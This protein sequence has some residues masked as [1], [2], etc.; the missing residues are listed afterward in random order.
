MYCWVGHRCDRVT[1][2]SDGSMKWWTC[3]VELLTENG[4]H[5]LHF[6]SDQETPHTHGFCLTGPFWQNYYKLGNSWL[7][8]SPEVNCYRSVAL[9]V[10][11]PTAVVQTPRYIPKK[12]TAGFLSGKL[13][14]KKNSK[15]P[16]PNLIQFHF[17]MPVIIKDLF[18]CKVSKDPEVMNLQIFRYS[19]QLMKLNKKPSWWA[20]STNKLSS[21]V[22]FHKSF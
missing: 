7:G 21:Q 14:E 10:G 22:S 3:D 11:Q 20:K 13:I 9:P 8:R 19:E 16:V 2:E 4:L 6:S 12:P 17:V 1:K 15:K 5:C 18:V